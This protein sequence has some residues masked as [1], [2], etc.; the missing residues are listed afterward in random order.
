LAT[1][2][3]FAV[4]VVV[5]FA[6]CAVAEAAAR[7]AA[8]LY[9]AS[10]DERAAKVEEWT[11]DLPDMT[12][13]ERLRHAG[14][15]L[16]AGAKHATLRWCGVAHPVRRFASWSCFRLTAV[17]SPRPGAAVGGL[18]SVGVL[19][20]I[21]VV[22]S[23]L[24]EPASFPW[25]KVLIAIVLS[26]CV[27]S[28]VAFLD[29]KVIGGS[30]HPPLR[31][32]IGCVLLN[33]PVAAGALWLWLS[34]RAHLRREPVFEYL[35]LPFLDNALIPMLLGWSITAFMIVIDACV[36]AHLASRFVDHGPK[37]G[38]ASASG[39]TSAAA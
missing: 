5:V 13:R 16:W 20:H 7:L 1:A 18:C 39:R 35:P 30:P 27:G 17:V 34:A 31:R 38:D 24:R 9:A 29:Q 37:R 2:S 33:A 8:R 26:A 4:V 14:S 32:I 19:V 36:L 15:L 12:A 22:G 23:L 11:R 25:A 28:F 3:V 21:G 6:Q 10:Q